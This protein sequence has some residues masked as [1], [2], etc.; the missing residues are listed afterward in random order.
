MNPIAY[1][2]PNLRHEINKMYEND[3]PLYV[4]VVETS[5]QDKNTLLMGDAYQIANSGT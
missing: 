5:F 4:V 2:V 3:C 1:S